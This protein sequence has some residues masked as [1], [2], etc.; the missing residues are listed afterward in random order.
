VQ[1]GAAGCSRG[2][3]GCSRGAAG[4][5]EV[6][7][8]AARSRGKQRC[9]QKVAVPRRMNPFAFHVH[10]LAWRYSL[11]KSTTDRQNHRKNPMVADMNTA[12]FSLFWTQRVE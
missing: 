11:T 7:Q 2:A 5:S 4:C 1:Q 3:A 9:L 8:G 12:A 6:R 10:L